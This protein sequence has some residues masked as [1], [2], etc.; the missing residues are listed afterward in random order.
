MTELAGA[1][2]MAPGTDEVWRHLAE[3]GKVARDELV[4]MASKEHEVG[5]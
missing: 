2:R 4:D 3:G 5:A 1:N